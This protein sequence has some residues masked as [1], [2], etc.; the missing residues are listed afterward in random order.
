MDKDLIPERYEKMVVM[1]RKLAKED[2]ALYPSVKSD[3]NK[4]DDL[5]FFFYSRHM[6]EMIV[7]YCNSER[8][9]D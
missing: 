4:E 8:V 5:N 1:A 3:V 2:V 6:S 9:D 7:L